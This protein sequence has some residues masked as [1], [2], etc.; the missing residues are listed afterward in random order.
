M[1][2]ARAEERGDVWALRMLRVAH[3]LKISRDDE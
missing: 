2:W 1:L 3:V